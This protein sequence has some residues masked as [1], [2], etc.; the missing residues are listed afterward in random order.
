[1]TA[2]APRRARSRQAAAV[3]AG[4]ALLATT[5]GLYPRMAPARPA[6]P[7]S[8]P[9]VFTVTLATDAVDWQPGDGVCETSPG[10]GRCTI[11]AAVLEAN[12]RPEGGPYVV[13]LPPGDYRL[14]IRGDSED[15]AAS[16][17]V[18]IRASLTLEGAGQDAVIVRG[19][20]EDLDHAL[21]VFPPATVRVR[22]VTI[23]DGA[24]GGIKNRRGALDIADSTIR[25]NRAHFGGGIANDGVLTLTRSI[26]AFNT[27]GQGG[28][29]VVFGDSRA[30]IRETR[31]EG[32]GDAQGGGMKV[33][34]TLDMADSVVVDNLGGHGGGIQ[35]LGANPIVIRDTLV[36]HNHASLHPDPPW[37]GYGGGIWNQAT[38]VRLINVTVSDNWGQGGGIYND[39]AGVITVT[40]ST[41]AFNGTHSWGGTINNL[42]AFWLANTIVGPAAQGGNCDVSRRDLTSLG[43][44]LDRDGGCMLRDPSD[45]SAIDPLVGPLADNGGR[46]LTHALLPD[47]PAIDA[48]DSA[49]CPHVDQ[50]GAPRPAGAGCDIGAFEYGAT[51]GAPTAS[52]T[53]T[54]TRPSATPTPT[55]GGPTPTATRTPTDTPEPPTPGSDIRMTG[56]VADR[57]TGAPVAG[58]RVAIDVCV[59]RQPFQTTSA[60]DGSYT[61]L[62]PA[63]YAEICTDVYLDVRA[64]GYIDHRQ[65]IRVADLRAEPRRDFLLDPVTVTTPTPSPP[66][67]TPTPTPTATRTSVP[68]PVVYLPR[69]DRNQTL[70]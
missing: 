52:L 9:N 28:G 40:N 31:I 2:Q 32:N 25:D 26:V 70:R 15:H 46:T 56:A 30:T 57:A 38:N 19:P 43:H 69:L 20:N 11:R 42:G 53:P 61:V 36:A 13:V 27:G 54:P 1:M 21:E 5:I 55:L 45:R 3:T 58:A 64:A 37:H 12:A 7:L 44:N 41:L 18:D 23:R 63:Q 17:D 34:G 22:G 65:I 35:L 68:A 10:D 33:M 50:R 24:G 8:A 29:I 47:S 48:A 14:T 16:G 67:P 4:F 6:A 60:A 62:L 51:A 39:A 66:T 59:P 49:H